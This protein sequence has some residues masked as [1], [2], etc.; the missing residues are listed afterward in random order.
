MIPV[1]RSVTAQGF[2]R[3]MRGEAQ[4]HLLSANDGRCYVVKFSNNP[5]GHRIL[6]NELI[7]SLLLRALG[8]A[9][10][11]VVLMHVDE[12]LL[13]DNPEVYFRAAQNGKA[14]VMPGI[15]LG[16]QYPSAKGTLAIYDFLPDC[17]LPRV[18]NRD[19]F[20]GALVFDK[21][22]SNADR[23]QAIFFRRR[24]AHEDGSLPANPWV[25]QMIDNGQIFQ[26]RE[27]TFHD[28]PIQGLYGRTIVYG[29]KPSLADCKPWLSA[30]LDLSTD[31]F[32]EILS[33][34]TPSWI[35]GH[36]S[37]L[38]HL[39]VRLAHRREHVPQ[40]VRES[41]ATVRNPRE[42]PALDRDRQ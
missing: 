2:V 8:I 17:I 12:Q 41:M 13:Q 18:E 4:A 32:D 37:D 1:P 14:P 3:K 42:N 33:L 27:W 24:V 28:S 22:T 36:E 5:Q 11:E 25:T 29:N 20:F 10:P 21:W 23:R 35:S 9:T 26:G 40:L 38:Q 19:H 16:S 30:L 39:L 6:V 7:G 31:I 34:V 15:H